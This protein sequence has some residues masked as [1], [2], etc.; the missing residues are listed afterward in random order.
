MTY[1]LKCRKDTESKNLQVAKTNKGKLNLLSECAVCKSKKLRFV[2]EQEA[3]EFL[4]YLGLKK[5]FMSN[6]SFG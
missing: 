4:N 5:N 3:S 6:S 1:C 2:K